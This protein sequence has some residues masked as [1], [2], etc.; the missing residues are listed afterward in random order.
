MKNK[1]TPLARDRK[2]AGD[3]LSLSLPE[4][5]RERERERERERD[6]KIQ[7]RFFEISPHGYAASLSH[8]I[9][10]ESTDKR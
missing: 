7:V 8:Q 9:D 1:A 5:S 6:K 2:I 4:E 3:S 10:D